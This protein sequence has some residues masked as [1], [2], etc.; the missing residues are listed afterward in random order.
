MKLTYPVDFFLLNTNN[1]LL[2]TK[3]LN[4]FL[5]QVLKVFVC[6]AEPD[7]TTSVSIC[8]LQFIWVGLLLTKQQKFPKFKNYISTINVLRRKHNSFWQ[9]GA[10]LAL[11]AQQ[12]GAFL[13]SS[14]NKQT[15]WNG[16]F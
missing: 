6:L 9:L 15:D 13:Y 7:Q 14:N 16:L 8:Q 3:L 1:Q 2:P 4:N 10:G 12:K 11:L 5:G